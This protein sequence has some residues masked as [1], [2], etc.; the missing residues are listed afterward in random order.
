M[1]FEATL[2]KSRSQNQKHS[3]RKPHPEFLSSLHWSIWALKKKNSLSSLSIQK[4]KKKHFAS[5]WRS[6]MFTFPDTSSDSQTASWIWKSI[7]ISAFSLR[8]L[9]NLSEE[10]WKA[11]S[12]RF[13]PSKQRRYLESWAQEFRSRAVVLLTQALTSSCFWR[14]DAHVFTRASDRRGPEARG[15]EESH[16][17]AFVA[18]LK[19]FLFG[20]PEV[21]MFGEMPCWVAF[22]WHFTRLEEASSGISAR[23]M[24]YLCLG[25]RI[26]FLSSRG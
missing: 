19:S 5:P 26:V 3:N 1:S 16:E 4:K 8:K 13:L 25:A 22:S 18:L 24:T 20:N 17:T 7:F 12:A 10:L 6:N 21:V 9:F 15:G 2:S 14:C 23:V 11:F